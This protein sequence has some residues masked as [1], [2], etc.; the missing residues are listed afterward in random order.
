MFAY[1]FSANLAACYGQVCEP[2]VHNH[3]VVVLFLHIELCDMV[4]LCLFFLDY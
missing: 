1:V 3:S 4:T 2:F